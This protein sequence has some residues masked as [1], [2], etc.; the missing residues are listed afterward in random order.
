MSKGKGP[1]ITVDDSDDDDIIELKD[2]HVPAGMRKSNKA[3]PIMVHDQDVKPVIPRSSQSSQGRI[4]SF[5][6]GPSRSQGSA[7]SESSQPKGM[8]T[9]RSGSRQAGG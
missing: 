6:S 7:K 1:M 3:P 9:S 4:D 2:D 8:L 5:L